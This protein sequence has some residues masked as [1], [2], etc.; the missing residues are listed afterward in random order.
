MHHR[1]RRSQGGM[2]SPSNVVRLCIRCHQW[3]TVNPL[4][5]EPLGWHIAGDVDPATVPVLIH[6]LGM[7]VLLDDLGMLTIA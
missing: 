5:A 3:V 4:D 6:M 7:R 2:W 1:R